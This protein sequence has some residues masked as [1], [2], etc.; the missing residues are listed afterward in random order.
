MCVLSPSG[1]GADR[2][3]VFLQAFEGGSIPRSLA[4]R[5]GQRF[6]V[7]SMEETED[8]DAAQTG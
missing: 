2:M 1:E 5:G 3:A 8:D 6:R 7:D 4:A